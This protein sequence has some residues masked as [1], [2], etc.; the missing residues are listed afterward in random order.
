MTR[1]E[2]DAILAEMGETWPEWK[3]EK[4]ELARWRTMFMRFSSSRIRQ[5][6]QRHWELTGWRSPRS[7]GVLKILEE[8]PAEPRAGPSDDVDPEAGRHPGVYIQCVESPQ[9]TRRLGRFVWVCEPDFEDPDAV[10][11]AL[12]YAESLRQRHEQLYRGQWQIIQPAT[13]RQMVQRRRELRA[14][15]NRKAV[16]E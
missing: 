10:R 5:A 3:P 13:P 2:A 8:K 9:G 14:P 15:D 12:E 11:H 4:E 7:G 1:D 6:V 16:P